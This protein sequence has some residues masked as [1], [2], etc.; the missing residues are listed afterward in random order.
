MDGWEPV[1]LPQ[2]LPVLDGKYKLLRPVGEGGMGTVYEAVHVGTGRHLAVKMIVGEDLAGNAVMLQRFQREARATGQIHSMYVAHTLDTGVEAKT[3]NPYLVME[4]LRGEDLQQA[5]RRLGPLSPVLALLIA[6]QTCLGLQKA[7]EAGVVHR[8]IKP[9]NIFLARHEGTEIVVKILDFGIAK[10]RSNRFASAPSELTQTGSLLGSPMYMS[11]EQA[12][13]KKTLDARADLWSLGV[14]L[15]EALTGRVPHT[16]DTVGELILQIC[17]EPARPIQERAPWVP[18]AV[19]AVVHRALALDPAARFGSAEEMHE[20]IRSLLPVGQALDSALF[21]PLPETART[22]TASFHSVPGGAAPPPPSSDPAFDETVQASS[23][24]GPVLASTT[25][26]FSQ[27]GLGAPPRRSRRSRLAVGSLGALALGGLAIGAAVWVHGSSPSPSTAAAA[28]VPMPL[29]ASAEPTAS[30]AASPSP[31][32]SQVNLTPLQAS[33]EPP[34][35]SPTALPTRARLLGPGATGATR[36]A[37]PAASAVPASAPRAGCTPP[38]TLDAN[39]TKVWK[40]E[41]FR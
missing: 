14:V 38:Y 29:A 28:S 10:V 9:S 40:R 3:G 22:R 35:P 7:H 1:D 18:S 27:P 33:T 30:A 6:A 11:P 13:G 21:Q 36:A 19:A 34:P 32:E 5:M 20:A 17:G 24:P 15:Y 39:G 12:R 41:C 31:A 37:P 2:P 25:G 4:L 26:G 16:A 8:D 23:S